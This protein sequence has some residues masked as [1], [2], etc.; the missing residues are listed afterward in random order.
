MNKKRILFLYMAYPFTLAHYFRHALEKRPDVELV[1]CGAYTGD[2]IP[3]GN[4]MTLP[5]KYV[6]QVDLPLPRTVT[7][8]SWGVIERKIGNE[9]DLVLN[10][11]AGFHLNDKPDGI[12]YA[13]VGT[14]PHVFNDNG[15]YDAVR[16]KADYF[17]NMQRYYMRDGDIH[18]P[19][20]CSPDHHY[21]MSNVEKR[22]DAS[23]I[24]LH[25]ESRTKLVSALRHRGMS[26]FYDIGQIWDEYRQTNNE[27][28]V[29]LNWSSLMDIN[30]RTF[31]MMA[32]MQVPVINRLPHL[33]ELGLIEGQHYLGFDSVQEGVEK[34]EWALAHPNQ[35][36]AIALSA[37]NLVHEKHTYELRVQQI[38]ET[39]GL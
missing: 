17:F 21:A 10:I 36:H 25:Y 37:H 28:T 1:T 31:E 7:L 27:S 16:T 18:L 12:P 35:A 20:A 32:M 29:G 30:A 8:P 39:V 5:A 19:Y 6:K 24:G 2:W 11:D 23:L 14:D 13:V 33:D 4:G 22:Y 38:L 9:F 34:T 15:W 3:W 26:V